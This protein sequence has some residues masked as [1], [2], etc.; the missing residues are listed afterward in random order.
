MLGRHV[1]RV[2][3]FAHHGPM[4]ISVPHSFACHPSTSLPALID[5]GAYHCFISSDVV[6]TLGLRTEPLC[7]PM[8]LELFDGTS[9]SAGPITRKVNSDVRIAD[10]HQPHL[11]FLVTRL[12]P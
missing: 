3:L 4:H 12:P 11:S 9:T 1:I 7:P 2:R 6:H 8:M 5:S 10:N